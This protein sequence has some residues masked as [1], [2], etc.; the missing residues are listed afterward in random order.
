[1]TCIP[2]AHRRL[3]IVWIDSGFWDPWP[4]WGCWAPGARC[5]WQVPATR[6]CHLS[7]GIGYSAENV[8]PGNVL[9]IDDRCRVVDVRL[10]LAL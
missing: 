9:T 6:F 2:V 4:S 8:S 7:L 3:S 10:L 1:M 5:F